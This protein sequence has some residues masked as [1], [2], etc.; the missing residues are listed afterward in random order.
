MREAATFI[1]RQSGY[2]DA[3]ILAGL[4]HTV[5][6]TVRV[7]IHRRQVV[8]LT[9]FDDHML[10]DI[11]LTRGDVRQALDLPFSQDPSLELRR[12]AARNRGRRWNV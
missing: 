7:W 4:L 12:L 9:Q 11:G 2:Q 1:A 10:A 6:S 5:A 8:D 3:G